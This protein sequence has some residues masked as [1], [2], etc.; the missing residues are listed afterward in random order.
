MKSPT[1]SYFTALAE[2]RAT[3]GGV[4]ETSFYPPLINLLN[5]VGETLKPRVLAVSQLKNVGAGSPDVGLFAAHQIPKG[6]A[7]PLPGQL[8]E[9]GAVE[10]KSVTEDSWLTANSAQ[11]SKYWTKYRLVLVTNYRDFLLVGTD[12]LGQPTVLETLRLATSADAFWARLAKPRGFAQTEGER[13]LEF[14]KRA[15]LCAAPLD[16]PRDVAWFLAS[17]PAM[18]ERGWRI[19]PIYRLWQPYARRWKMRWACISTPVMAS[20]SFAPP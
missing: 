13:V 6:E 19:N 15:L 3:G 11:V 4:K 14:L 12:R 8:P 18:R 1:E 5:A 7:E 9:R 2:V 16:N 10:V 20:I 17:M